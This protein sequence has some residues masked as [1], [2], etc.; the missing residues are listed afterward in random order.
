[1]PYK[2]IGDKSPVSEQPKE[3]YLKGK[4]RRWEKCCLIQQ[5]S[6]SEAFW[7]P[8]HLA[9][10]S[11][12]VRVQMCANLVESLGEDRRGLREFI[13]HSQALAPPPSEQER[14]LARTIRAALHYMC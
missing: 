6:R 2:E 9:D 1:M 4:Q 13:A 8:E 10:W 12:E 11:R 5:R 14:H 7:C 3:G